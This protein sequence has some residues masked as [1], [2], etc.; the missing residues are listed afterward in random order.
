[1]RVSVVVVQDGD[2]VRAY[3]NSC[4]HARTP[5]NW[6]EDRFFDLSGTYLFCTTHGAAFDVASGRCVRGPAKGQALTP[7]QVHLE[8]DRIM[9]DLSRLPPA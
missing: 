7:V 5:L 6:Q 1:M 2:G 8:N 3:I 9:T 4:P